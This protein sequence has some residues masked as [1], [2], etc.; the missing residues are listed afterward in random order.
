MATNDLSLIGSTKNKYSTKK[1]YGRDLC[2]A[3]GDGVSY[4][5]LMLLFP[6]GKQCGVMN[7]L[8]NMQMWSNAL[9]SLTPEL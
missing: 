7:I 3:T 6:L 5:V 8:I 1:L 2:F 4:Y 9:I